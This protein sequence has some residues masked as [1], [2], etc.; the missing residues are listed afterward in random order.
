M[1]EKPAEPATMSS[2]AKAAAG[3]TVRHSSGCPPAERRAF[4]TAT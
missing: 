4:Y 3:Y 2:A 1:A